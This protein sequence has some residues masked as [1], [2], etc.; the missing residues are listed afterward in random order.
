LGLFCAG[1]STPSPDH[2][3]SY[4]YAAIYNNPLLSPGAQFA[5][6]P[7]AVQNTIR[8]ET[9]S[10]GIWSINK[11]TSGDLTFYRIDFVNRGLPPLFVSADG[12][13]LDANLNVLVKAPAEKVSQATGAPLTTLMLSQ[14]PPAVVRSIQLRASDAEVATIDKETHGDQTTYFITFKDNRHSPLHLTSDG[15]PLP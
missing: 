5:A 8:A 14:L 1:C 10:T 12:S 15:T 11:D 6:T 4:D 2:W 9:G 7:P 3:E 13:V